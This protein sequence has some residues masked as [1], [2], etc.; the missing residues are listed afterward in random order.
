MS[1]K[2]IGAGADPNAV[3]A[4][5]NG[6][7][8]EDA[9]ILAS[10]IG[11][12][13]VSEVVSTTDGE[14]MKALSYRPPMKMD[15]NGEMVPLQEEEWTE[16][17]QRVALHAVTK[18]SEFYD[19][20]FQTVMTHFRDCKDEIFELLARSTGLPVKKI[21][22]MSGKAFVSLVYDY[23]SR[24]EFVDFFTE[25]LRRLCSGLSKASMSASPSERG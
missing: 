2:D 12:I 9:F 14:M 8:A 4:I 6:I 7:M 10:V 16:A 18:Q 20:L 24:E 15:E 17:Q 19:K 13:G 21:E 3:P 25:A 22:E 11:K 23:I 1:K 5:I